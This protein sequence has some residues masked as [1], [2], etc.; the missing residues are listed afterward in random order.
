MK[1]VFDIQKINSVYVT[2]FLRWTE[3]TGA[4]YTSL[5]WISLAKPNASEPEVG[6]D[7]D[8]YLPRSLAGRDKPYHANEHR[9]ILC[10]L[11]DPN[12]NKGEDC[13]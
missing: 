1:S 5:S 2:A 13:K 3:Y 9:W 7:T 4:E 10:T 12:D 8:S 11:R 6:R